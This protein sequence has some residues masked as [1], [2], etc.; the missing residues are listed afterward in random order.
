MH[1][2]GAGPA[3]GPR[4][5]LKRGLLDP[6]L[7]ARARDRMWALNQVV[8]LDRA[9]PA[10]WVGRFS[11]DEACPDNG[12]TLVALLGNVYLGTWP[13]KRCVIAGNARHG[14]QQRDRWRPLSWA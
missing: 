3:R 10:T 8:R 1:C 7:C 9:E 11:D 4:Y 6:E 14:C 2:S 5:L 13:G 12:A